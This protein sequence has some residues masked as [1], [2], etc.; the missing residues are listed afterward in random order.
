MASILRRTA[1]ILGPPVLAAVPA[2]LLSVVPCVGQRAATDLPLSLAAVPRFPVRSSPIGLVADARPR[3]YLGVTGPRRAWLGRETG[4]AEVW[5]HPLKVVADLRLAFKVPQY[6]TPV[7]G[8]DVVS[9]V[10]VRPEATTITYTHMAFTVREHIIA[11]RDQA[12]LVMLLEVETFVP[13][14]VVVQ[15]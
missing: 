5:V 3:E 14:E 9:R 7:R 13:L 4:F 6:R 2:L 11:P 8:E 1:Q 10:E 15:F 12:G